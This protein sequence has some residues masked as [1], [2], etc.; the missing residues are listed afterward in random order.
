MIT[1]A[2]CVICSED[3]KTFGGHVHKGE[4]TVIAAT[5]REHS[6]IE[7]SGREGCKGCYGEWNENMGYND[8]DANS[9]RTYGTDKSELLKK[10]QA[11]GFR[12]IAITVMI[13]EETFV[14]KTE[15]ESHEAYKAMDTNDG[16]WYGLDGKYPW[17]KTWKEYVDK[18][19]DG[20]ESKAP[21]VY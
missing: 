17:D 9:N 19:Y 4:D 2:K 12:P 5:C 1:T 21:K 11:A 14:F 8:P 7:H 18:S 15:K 6:E 10:V 20:D 16:W 3:A 13:C